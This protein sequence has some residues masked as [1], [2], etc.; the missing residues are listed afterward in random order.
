MRTDFVW[1]IQ[2]CLQKKPFSKRRNNAKLRKQE[3][4]T[5]N[6][7][8]LKTIEKPKVFADNILFLADSSVEP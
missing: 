4:L 3:M 8:R 1:G 6:A 5:K 7:N 2:K